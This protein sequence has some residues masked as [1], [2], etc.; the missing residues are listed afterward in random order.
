MIVIRRLPTGTRAIQQAVAP[1]RNAILKTAAE[2][3]A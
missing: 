1:A 3:L 2:L